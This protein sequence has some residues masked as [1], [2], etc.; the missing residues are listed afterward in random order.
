[1][2]VQDIEKTVGE[3]PEKEEDGDERDGDDGLPG[4]DLRGSGDDLVADTLPTGL[5]VEGLDR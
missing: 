2:L 3:T 1:M 4:G 5:Q